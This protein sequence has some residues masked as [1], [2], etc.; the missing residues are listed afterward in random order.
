MARGSSVGR[1]PAA[2]LD[3]PFVQKAS[4][5]LGYGLFRSRELILVV[6]H[7]VQFTVGD[8]T[9]GHSFQ[10]EFAEDHQPAVESLHSGESLATLQRSLIF[11]Y[12][13]TIPV[14]AGS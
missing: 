2:Q 12:G 14:W 5:A 10:K 6:G 1:N 13:S 3:R 7:P 4:E 8:H 11:R 9:G